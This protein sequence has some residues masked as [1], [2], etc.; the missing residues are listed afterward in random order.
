MNPQPST[1][2]SYAEVR[3][4]DREKSARILPANFSLREPLIN[5]Q[6][7]EPERRDEAFRL[8]RRLTADAFQF[9]WG[10]RPEVALHDDYT[11]INRRDLSQDAGPRWRPPYIGE[12]RAEFPA[13]PNGYRVDPAA[14]IR[15]MH[16]G[17]PVIDLRNLPSSLVPSVLERFRD[18]LADALSAAFGERPDIRFDFESDADDRAADAMQSAFAQSEDEMTLGARVSG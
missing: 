14:V 15:S 11:G 10:R 9:V 4:P 6:C 13:D 8:F 18:M 7:L 1:M 3:L 17:D 2:I 5:A 16:P 12:I